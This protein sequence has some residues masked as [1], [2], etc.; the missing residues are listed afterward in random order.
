MGDYDRMRGYG[1]GRGR[2]GMAGNRLGREYGRD[3]N[4]EDFDR[5]GYGSR[6][7]GDYGYGAGGRDGGHRT[8]Y[9]GD[10]YERGDYGRGDYGDERVHSYGYPNP[11]RDFGGGYRERGRYGYGRD[12]RRGRDDDRGFFERAGDEI[13]TWFG[14][15]DAERR[16][17]RDAM[18]GDQGAQHHRGRGPRGYTRSDDRIREDVNDRL[19]E[20]PYLD[21][22]DIEVTV[23]QGEVT[24]NGTVDSRAA[25]RRA[26]DIVDRISGVTHSQ[27]N[28]RVRREGTAAITSGTAGTGGVL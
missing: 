11:D 12:D 15:D 7:G 23:S 25:K 3:R 28:L 10:E 24:L 8:F 13:A 5:G 21:A 26:E 6:S 1:E 4:D 16:R 9:S 22:S 14:S 19:T 17:R 20:D 18:E 27:N 2:M